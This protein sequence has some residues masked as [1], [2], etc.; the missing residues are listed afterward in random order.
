MN[1]TK[2]A[3]QADFKKQL[4]IGTSKK[5][6]CENC[7]KPSTWHYP[8]YDIFSDDISG[9]THLCNDCEERGLGDE[10][11]FTCSCC[12]RRMIE[13]ITWEKYCVEVDGELQ[14]LACAAKNY[15][16]DE[17]NLIDPAKVT[18]VIQ[19]PKQLG[20]LFNPKTGV[21]NLCRVKHVLGVNQPV[22]AGIK[23]VENFE[24]CNDRGA[25]DC[26]DILAKIK[27]QTQPVYLVL[28]GAYQFSISIGQYVRE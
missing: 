26:G 7:N 12:D 23:F 6:A 20:A 3:N 9:V 21:V 19:E 11:F 2:V 28:D 24:N 27:E 8:Y 1:A 17:D 25:F 4:S 14:C 22:P 10:G 13:N 5:H 15:F 16:A 18:A